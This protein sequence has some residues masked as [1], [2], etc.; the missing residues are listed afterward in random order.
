MAFPRWFFLEVPDTLAG[1]SLT[2]IA[3]VTLIWGTVAIVAAYDH[4]GRS[5]L[6]RWH[7]RRW[8]PLSFE[9]FLGTF[10]VISDAGIYTI[11]GV[12]ILRESDGLDVWAFVYVL[13]C[14]ALALAA[15]GC[16]ARERMPDKERP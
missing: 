2:T 9:F 13:I 16:W 15:F 5:D 4:H 7:W 1:I 10:L 12:S 6:P 3:L 8:I 14:A 11:L